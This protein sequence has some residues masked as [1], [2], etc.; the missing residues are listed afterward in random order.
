MT[1]YASTFDGHDLASLFAIDY[2]MERQLP[3]WEPTLVDVPGRGS[4]FGGTRALPVTI[5]MTLVTQAPTRDERQEA[6]RTLAGWLAV[7]E[8]RPLYLGDEGGRYRMAVPTEEAEVTPYLDADAVEVT[9]TCPDPL[10]HGTRMRATVPSGGTVRIDVGGTAPA[11]PTISASAAHGASG[12]GWSVVTDEGRGIYANIAQDATRTLVADVA[13]RTLV[14]GGSAA[15]LDTDYDWPTMTPGAR[16]LTMA[17]GT[18]EAVVEWE[19][20]WW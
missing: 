16:T 11:Q 13:H 6:L 18:G 7:D 12:G 4:L 20:L 14:V 15:M 5:R 10:L 1:E 17:L 2:Q 19:E 9:F 8:P 3:V